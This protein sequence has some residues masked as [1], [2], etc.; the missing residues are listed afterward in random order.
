VSSHRQGLLLCLV[1]AAG[2]GAMAIFAKNAY[3]A[4][5]GVVTLLALRFALAT[6]LLWAIAVA[7]GPIRLPRRTALAALGL[8]AIGYS[9]QAGAF[10]AALERID[11]SLASLL[12]YA[13]PGLVFAGAVLLRR[14]T[15]TRR[16][17]GALGLASLGAALVLAGG[18]PGAVDPVGVALALGAAV[19]YTG[20]ILVADSTVQGADPFIVAAIVTTGAA[21][22]FG[23]VAVASG[24]LDLDVAAHG[25]LDLVGVALV[26]TVM[27]LTT[28]LLGLARVGAATASIV[29]TV[30]PV[31][32][33]GLAVAVL[34]ETLG[35]AQALGGVLVLAA[36]VLLQRRAPAATL[37]SS[38]A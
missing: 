36:V 25:W 19:A 4:G 29:S 35:P 3:A 26:S 14:E 16:K 10:F 34:G 31:V 7:R 21:A 30:E 24:G 11:A 33:V 18:G 2:F 8:G 32:T 28:F 27:A 20:Y 23:V 1:S 9:A 15:A 13:Y 37:R 22:T 17:L 6:I 12:L 38:A 5:F